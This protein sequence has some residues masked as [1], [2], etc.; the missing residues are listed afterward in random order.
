VARSQADDNGR[1]DLRAAAARL[2]VH[3]QT[4]YAWVRRGELRA[5]KVG[6]SYEIAER[7][8]ERFERNRAQ[9]AL[10]TLRVG[11]H[12]RQARLLEAALVAGDEARAGRFVKRLTDMRL[13]AVE[14]LDLIVAPAMR[15]IGDAWLEGAV[16]VATEHRASAICERL[17]A[18]LPSPRVR[19]RGT[20]VVAT[21]S[22]ELH[23]VPAAMAAAAL[24]SDGWRVHYLA[25]QVPAADLAE[26]AEGVGAD[27]V[28]L[29]T[30]LPRPESTLRP[31]RRAAMGARLLV[32]HPGDRVEELLTLADEARRRD[33]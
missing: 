26:F 23:T 4:A 3:Y 16:S 7:E 10:P 24:R 33:F 18:R 5:T 31:Y 1:V 30:T 2:G 8:I 27:V 20:A 29:S 14:L 17:L 6:R 25:A 9:R 22:G 19:V 32:G 15:A 11:D 28:V 13:P 21:P 12:A